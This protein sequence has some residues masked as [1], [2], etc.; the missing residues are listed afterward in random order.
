MYI[1]CVVPPTSG[2]VA[3]GAGGSAM[4]NQPKAEFRTIKTTA[5]TAMAIAKALRLMER[6][7]P[8]TA[9]MRG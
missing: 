1:Y 8:V 6:S 2:A 9:R 7:L 5:T 3:A 4:L